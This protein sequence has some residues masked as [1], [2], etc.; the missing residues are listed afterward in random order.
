M[1]PRKTGLKICDHGAGLPFY[2]LKSKRHKWQFS[3]IV[4][5]SNVHKTETQVLS[6]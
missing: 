1:Q 3:A 6:K 2:V 5:V 4:N